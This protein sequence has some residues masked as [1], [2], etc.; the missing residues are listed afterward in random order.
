MFIWLG[1]TVSKH[2]LAVILFWIA[3]VVVLRLVAP[4]WDD[5]TNDGDFAFLP[6]NL[7]SV[8]GE[9]LLERAF[10]LNRA[11]SQIVL[12][13]VRE[14]GQIQD[15]DKYVANDLARRFYN[16]YGAASFE[17]GKKL[18]RDAAAAAKRGAK[19]EGAALAK[20]SEAALQAAG[21]AFDEAILID[22]GLIDYRRGRYNR[23][24][25]AERSTPK[26]GEDTPGTRRLAEAYF[27]RALWNNYRGQND[28]AAEDRK[29]ALNYNPALRGRK[30]LVAPD[31]AAQWPLLD[32]WTWHDDVLGNMLGSKHKHARLI[33]LQLESEFTATD[34]IRLL[35]QV[36]TELDDVRASLDS[37]ASPGLTLGYSGSAAVGGGMLRSAQE[38]IQNTELFTIV[39]VLLILGAVYRAPLLV[40]VPL[41]AITISFLAATSIV[42]I[43]TQVCKIPGLGWFELKVFTTTKIF[44]VV[45]LYGSGTDFCLF[46]ISRYKEELDAGHGRGVAVSRA[47]AAVGDAL[48]A[49]AFTTI[50]GLA[51][52]AFAGFGKFRYSGPVIG[53]CL[54]FTLLACLTLAPAMLRACGSLVFWPFGLSPRAAPIGTISRRQRGYAPGDKSSWEFFWN[55]LA[56]II[57]AY[58]GRVLILALL[59][60]MP[61]AL[62]GLGSGNHVTYDILSSLSPD[63]PSRQGTEL[64][65]RH[66][67]IGESG[68]LTVIVQHDGADFNSKEDREKIEQLTKDLYLPGVLAVRSIADPLGDFARRDKVSILDMRARMMKAHRRTAGIFVA[69]THP[70]AGKVTRFELILKADPFS[71]EAAQ[72]LE[73][74]E[75]KLQKLGESPDSYWQGASFLYAGTTAGIRDL[76][77][78]TRADNTRIMI[79]VVL[80]VLA[81]LLVILKRP[82]IC[83]YMVA[84]VLFTYYLTIG[85][86]EL[87]FRWAYGDTY[88]GLDWKLPLFLF[89]ILV[90]I[91]QDYNVYLATRV[92]EEQLRY[93]QLAGLR[94]AIV[95]T[96]GIIT[97]CG[98]IMAGTFVAMTS[99][100]WGYVIP[101]WVPL[102]H[103]LFGAPHGVLRAIV[104][105]G[106]SL[107]LGVLLDTFV[108]RSVLVPAFMALLIRWSRVPTG[109]A[110]PVKAPLDESA[111]KVSA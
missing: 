59:V 29:R 16:F 34:N 103:S 52:M 33:I 14:E 40:A 111:P 92:F 4:N 74:V 79:L 60:M 106:V 76:R 78:V 15:D 108:V 37:V 49:S 12:V 22:N 9:E 109:T 75:Q 48:T 7:P 50:F 57:V 41:V 98:V 2:W 65:K 95:V 80:A 89:V 110:I 66:F 81:V 107:T 10:P 46:L 1:K 24:S 13:T 6:S 71:P 97:S 105:L 56:R 87:F 36:E 96:G 58:P 21:E 62:F 94:R 11:R 26:P 8:A 93:G 100:T 83:V 3:L 35:E 84:S 47:L 30:D 63:S 69:Q 102:A 39:L 73:D 82:V 43:L 64:L 88:V 54:A 17:R 70:L 20:R 25:S 45:I 27:N 72:V 91:G 67:N 31:G 5:I 101:E 18:A 90:A 99:G 104:E 28:E 85:A 38:S 42:A 32:V 55:A 53:L 51:M 86:T 77:A 68:P 19:E 44:I 23:V 61:L